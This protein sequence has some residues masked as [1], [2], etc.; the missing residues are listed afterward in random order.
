MTG[1]DAW[2]L[3]PGWPR[4]ESVER[5]RVEPGGG[6]LR[7]PEPDP[8]RCRRLCAALR[9]ARNRHVADRKARTLAAT[10]GRVG[11]RFLQAGDPIRERALELLPGLSGLSSPMAREV[12][13]GMARDWT[14]GRLHRLLCADFGDPAVL[15]RFR[16]GR[17]GGSVRALGPELTFHVGAGTVPGVSV[18]SV[19]RGLLVKSAVILKPGRGDSLLPVLF[20]RALSQ[21]DP[22][23]A[24]AVAV[25]YWPGGHETVEDVLLGQ[26][27]AVVAYGSDDT[28]R[29]LR[30]RTPLA[31]RFV[32]YRHRLSAGLLGRRALSGRDAA[33]EAAA[34]AA[35]A[36]ALFDQRGCVSP[37]V[38]YVERGG[39]V[40]PGRWAE[41]LAEAFEDLESAL[42]SGALR[43]GEASEIQ[44][45]RGTAE[46]R[47]SAGRGV[48]VHHG[49]TDP[50]TV[51]LEDE[52]GFRP[53]CLGRVVRLRPVDGLEEAVEELARIGD[54]LQTVSVDGAGPE[55]PGLAEELARAGASRI[56]TL[57][58]AP[59]PPAWWHHDG[60]GSL[61]A[62]VRWVDLENEGRDSAPGA[63]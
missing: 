7:F 59:W 55:R 46:L 40:G 58:K 49:G 25:L 20:A 3:P 6:E 63:S 14:G 4:P 28:V 23:L 8:D 12:L 36:V 2:A 62:L 35:R 9:S 61:R 18:T 50:W 29:S 15:D 17:G 37:H 5:V 38:L 47:A 10:L 30:E 27:G 42:P 32:G 16:P 51:L 19:I 57:E 52:A 31:G 56:T 60:R 33:A 45:L 26:S 1:F 53:S 24:G 41:L 21:E 43:A 11:S 39:G 34:R 13:D 48:E 22:E 54:R 44:Q